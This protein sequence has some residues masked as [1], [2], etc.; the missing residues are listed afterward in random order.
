MQ[1]AFTLLSISEIVFVFISNHFVNA[2]LAV[3]W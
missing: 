3:K 1:K 2:C